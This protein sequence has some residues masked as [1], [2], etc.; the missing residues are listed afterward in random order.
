MTAHETSQA[1]PTPPARGSSGAVQ[2]AHGDPGAAAAAPTRGEELRGFLQSLLRLQCQL[3][4]G[5]AGV[6]YLRPGSGRSGGTAATFHSES[7]SELPAAA[8]ESLEKV[9]A[10]AG[11]GEGSPIVEPVTVSGARDL[12]AAGHTHLAMAVPLRAD[13]RVEGATAVLAPRELRDQDAAMLRLGL[14]VSR[15]ESFLWRQSAL[16]EAEQKVIV[17]E[18]LELL[19]R[20][21]QG[22]T[23]QSMSSLMCDELRRR[24]GCTRVSIGLVA[25]DRVRVI[26]VSGSEDLDPHAPAIEALEGAMEETALQDA[27][28]LLPAPEADEAQP[29]QRRV[30]HEHTRLSE[31]YGPSAIVSLP[32]RIK[33][34]LIGVMVLERHQ[35][36]LFP[37]AVLPLLR[38]VAEFV[39]PAVYTRRLADRRVLSVARDDL[40]DVGAAIVGPR[41][42]AKKL[43]GALLIGALLLAALVPIPARVSAPI[44]LRA[45]TARAIVPPFAGYLD[46][47]LVRPGDEV[48]AGDL[49]A[50]M[51]TEQ[52]ELSLSEIDAR[53]ETLSARHDN[54]MARGERAASRQAQAELDEAAASQR[55]IRQRIEASELRAPIAGVV[56]QG[57]LERLSGA[58]VDATQVLL[59]VV[60]NSTLAILEVS[61]GDIDRV[62]LGQ[63]GFITVRGA[64]DRRV[65]VE[66]VRINPVAQLRDTRS[67]FL[68][69][70]AID[71]DA[72]G[73]FEALLRPGMT[74]SVR[75]KAGWSTAL[76]ELSR[77]LTD[78][79]RIRLWW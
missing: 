39:G 70:A 12:Y 28:V 37:S 36:D 3:T 74:G 5:E 41:H 59:E 20:A 58:P 2:H 68:V 27:E 8:L 15:F 6:A 24:F 35:T 7:G 33:G 21:Q 46:R 76:W 53:I 51:A 48:S 26:A 66:V 52:L 29:A 69:E 25:G 54:A 72:A 42:T 1:G 10:R 50:V 32:L 23:A 47:S 14:T 9:A 13:G 61:E 34:D 45:A 71:R 75:L 73:G 77:P 79:A 65:P 30:I 67:V 55:L 56:S 78:A 57:D 60:G 63:R 40:L 22:E 4:S 49:L 11:E 18:T 38:L 19:D 31:A 17:K 62:K 44:E 64:P 16:H 43:V